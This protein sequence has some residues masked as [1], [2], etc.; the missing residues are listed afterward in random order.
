MARK[1]TPRKKTAAKKFS[2]TKKKVKKFSK[3]EML[4]FARIY[5]T[6]GESKD[7]QE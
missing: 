5:S 3:R 4:T 6:L 1:Y 7:E 2:S